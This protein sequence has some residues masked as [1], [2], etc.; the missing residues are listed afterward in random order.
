MRSNWV[1]PIECSPENKDSV[2]AFFFY[3]FEYYDQYWTYPTHT[4]A[5]RI[6]KQTLDIS[7]SH[8]GLAYKKVYGG[9]LLQ[10]QQQGKGFKL[11]SKL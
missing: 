4:F 10:W 9:P 11:Y 5:Y 2:K 7:L 6:I 1:L 8:F 3:A